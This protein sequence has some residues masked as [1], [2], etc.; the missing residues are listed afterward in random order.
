M[1]YKK[2]INKISNMQDIKTLYNSLG[3]EEIYD[4]SILTV[5]PY[6]KTID[7]VEGI[8]LNLSNMAGGFPFMFNNIL[9]KNSEVLYLCGEF[10]NRD[11]HCLNIQKELYNTT[12]GYGAKKFI[13]V[14][15][16]KDIRKD[17][18]EFRLDWMLYVIWE[19]CKGCEAFRNKLKEIPN[20]VILVEE[21]TTDNSGSNTIWGCS[22]KEL[23]NVRKAKEQEIIKNNTNIKKKCL[24]DLINIEIN[25]IRNVGI[26]VGQNNMGKILMLCK[27]CIEQNIEPPINKDIL[28]SKNIY[29][30][31]KK[32]ELL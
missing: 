8:Q 18:N 31:G 12:S 15:Y 9:F 14:K 29:I 27:K 4:P 20:N 21:T 7:V 1:C 13:K 17:F 6:K 22:N 32:I 5:W 3:K 19:K 25:K 30:F 26:Y 10:S 11:E 28:N 23:V 16:L 24:N 2:I